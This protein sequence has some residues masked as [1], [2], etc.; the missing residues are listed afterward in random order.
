MVAWDLLA[1]S[2]AV[3]NSVPKSAKW[4]IGWENRFC[5]KSGLMNFAVRFLLILLVRK[6]A[7]QRS[8]IDD[9][10]LSRLGS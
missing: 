7:E 3:A 8:W 9:A 5:R 1:F 2:A 4:L 6:F 10:I